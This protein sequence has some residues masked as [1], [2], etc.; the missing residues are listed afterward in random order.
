MSENKLVFARAYWMNSP[1]EEGQAGFFV[2]D[3]SN[4]SKGSYEGNN[5]LRFA[6]AKVAERSS[7]LSTTVDTEFEGLAR[8]GKMTLLLQP[9]E[10]DTAKYK[11]V[12]ELARMYL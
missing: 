11:S 10:Q 9:I 7:E 12:D 2:G 6:V 4:P 8:D 3:P 1:F 5:N